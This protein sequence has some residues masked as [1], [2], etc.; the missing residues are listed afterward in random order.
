MLREEKG[1][2]RWCVLGDFNSIPSD[3]ERKGVEQRTRQEEMEAFQQFISD[4]GLFDLPLVGRKFTWYRASGSAMN[5]LDR[6]IISELWLSCW[7]GLLQWGLLRSVSDHCVVVLKEREVDCGPKPF[8]FLNC[9]KDVTGYRKFVENT[10][11]EALVQGRS[12]YVLKEKL[13]HIKHELH[14]WNKNHCGIIE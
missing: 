1:G 3:H 13:K 7:P 10:W 14:T 2:E 9:W 5:R 11:V 12:A 8:H 4:A 6:F